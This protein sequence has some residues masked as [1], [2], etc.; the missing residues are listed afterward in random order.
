M[1]NKT[2]KKKILEVKGSGRRMVYQ[3][4]S[5][6]FHTTH[7]QEDIEKWVKH[8]DDDKGCRGGDISLLEFK[9]LFNLDPYDWVE[10]FVDEDVENFVLEI[11][12]SDLNQ[13]FDEDEIKNLCK[14]DDE[15]QTYLDEE[16]QKHILKLK[17][18]LKILQSPIV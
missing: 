11:Q 9:T 13:D 10:D 7:K 5:G 15:I 1:K 16:K 2:M 3:I 6:Y 18:E 4:G 12:E 8:I 14:F 17:E